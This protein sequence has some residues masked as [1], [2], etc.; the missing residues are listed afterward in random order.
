MRGLDRH[1]AIGSRS[2]G[3]RTIPSARTAMTVVPE[4]G[5]TGRLFLHGI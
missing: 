5:V 1:P 2:Q 3:T 4:Y